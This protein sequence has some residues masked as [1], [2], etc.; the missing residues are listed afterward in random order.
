MFD[1]TINKTDIHSTISVQHVCKPNNDF[2]S[3]LFSC[4][5][6][7]QIQSINVYNVDLLWIDDKEIS[8]GST[9]LV[10]C[11]TKIAPAV[12]LRRKQKTEVNAEKNTFADYVSKKEMIEHV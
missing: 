11:G 8:F 2:V 6:K 7:Q 10:K 5:G 12:I 1:A 4:D 9:Y 3:V